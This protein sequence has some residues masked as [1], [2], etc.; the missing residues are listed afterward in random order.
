MPEPEAP[1]I[2]MRS[3]ERTVID[4]PRSTS[5]FTAPWMKSFARSVPWSTMLL[6]FGI[7][8]VQ[9]AQS[10]RRDSAGSK[11]AARQAG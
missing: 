7:N 2:A 5:S 4:A 1:T 11:R 3:P 8:W 10:L 6:E 9:T